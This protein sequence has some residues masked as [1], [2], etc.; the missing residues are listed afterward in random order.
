[1]FVVS[2]INGSYSHFYHYSSKTY[3]NKT[4]FFTKLNLRRTCIIILLSIYFFKIR[5]ALILILKLLLLPILFIFHFRFD[6]FGEKMSRNK[7]QENN[8][9]LFISA[10]FDLLDRYRCRYFAHLYLKWSP[11]DILVYCSNDLFFISSGT[12][13]WFC[14]HFLSPC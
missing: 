8:K 5:H 1:M 14:F 2:V 9:Y 11:N 6:A 7:K 3:Y 13:F 10:Q 12:G 4:F